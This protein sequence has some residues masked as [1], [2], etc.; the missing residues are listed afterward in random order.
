METGFGENPMLKQRHR[1]SD[2]KVEI[3]FRENPML[4]YS[5]RPAAPIPSVRP[6]F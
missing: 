6:S 5:D 4:K 2:P 3:R 1:A